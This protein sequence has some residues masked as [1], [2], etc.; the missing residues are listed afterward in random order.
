MGEEEISWSSEQ[1]NEITI[2]RQRERQES[3]IVSSMVKVGFCHVKNDKLSGERELGLKKI[4]LLMPI[5][6]SN[7]T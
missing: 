5:W 3:F 7:F 4:N 1:P 6:P 2:L